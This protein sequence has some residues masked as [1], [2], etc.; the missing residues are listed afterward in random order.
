MTKK[1]ILGQDEVKKLIP[2]L[3]G[4]VVSNKI[5]LDGLP[6]GF[7]YRDHTEEKMWSL[8]VSPLRNPL[9]TH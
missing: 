5:T 2:A 6:V 7:M 4:C 1:F 9:E 3:G 8:P